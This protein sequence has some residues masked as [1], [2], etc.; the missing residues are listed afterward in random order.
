MKTIKEV[1]DLLEND[2]C[3]KSVEDILKEWGDS[4]VTEC[5]EIAEMWK[6][7][8]TGFTSGYVETVKQQIK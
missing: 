8:S 5:E 6:S 1:I 7:E 3:G 4:I 2:L